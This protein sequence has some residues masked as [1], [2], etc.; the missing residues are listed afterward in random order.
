[1]VLL[2]MRRW[3]FVALSLFVFW[4]MGG[5][6]VLNIWLLMWLVSWFVPSKSKGRKKLGKTIKAM[7]MP[8]I[9]IFKIGAQ[10]IVCLFTWPPIILVNIVLFRDYALP[11]LFENPFETK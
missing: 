9:F 7:F 3:T 2:G 5:V 10:V 4:R 1:M 11:W 6:H 8:S